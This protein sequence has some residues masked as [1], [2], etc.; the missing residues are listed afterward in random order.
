MM[1]NDVVDLRVAKEQSDWKRKGWLSKIFTNEEQELIKE[2]KNPEVTVWMFWSMKETVYKAH[3][4]NTG[5]CPKLNP[6]DFRCTM[7]QEVLV[8]QLSYKVITRIHDKYI[9]TYT[10]TSTYQFLYL[11]REKITTSQIISELAQRLSIKKEY[12]HFEKTTNG[13]PILL[14]SKNKEQIP[15]SKSHHGIYE[16]YVI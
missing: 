12:L 9:H 8:D 15:F 14:N 1:G 11:R 5:F 4:R 2:S 6:K 7:H 3:Q 16:A 10:A 13:L